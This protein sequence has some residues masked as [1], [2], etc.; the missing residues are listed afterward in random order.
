MTAQ[1]QDSQ[2]GGELKACPMCDC[3]AVCDYND[4]SDGSSYWFTVGCSDC[5]LLIDQSFDNQE[6]AIAAWNRRAARPAADAVGELEKMR[7]RKDAAY[8]ERN[9][10]VAA[11]AKLFPSGTARTNIP[12]W[13]DDWHGCVYIDLPTGQVSW[14][15]HDS[16]AHLFADLPP[17]QGVWDGHDTDEKYRR[18][19]ATPASAAPQDETPIRYDPRPEPDFG[20]AMIDHGEGI[21]HA[22]QD[23]GEAVMAAAKAWADASFLWGKRA[24][25]IDAADYP[26]ASNEAEKTGA[27]FAPAL[28]AH[29]ARVRREAFEEAAKVADEHR[30]RW[31]SA[32]GFGGHS[33]AARIIAAMI[34]ATAMKDAATMRKE[35]SNG[36]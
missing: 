35:E 10:V 9:K 24:G 16:Q 27:A 4:S 1:P 18:L 23:D 17:Y 19:A 3:A 7:A 5:N 34:R 32:G 6:E 31:S 21:I 29:T 12:G 28:S 20:A 11:L 15:F 14:H 8:E 13:S 30:D 36:D 33:A 2:S 26:R 25:A 22:P